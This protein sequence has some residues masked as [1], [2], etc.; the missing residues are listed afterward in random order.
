MTGIQRAALRNRAESRMGGALLGGAVALA[1]L[2]SLPWLGASSE[3]PV[4]AARE[5]RPAVSPAPFGPGHATDRPSALQAHSGPAG[6]IEALAAIARSLG[7]RRIAVCAA[8]ERGSGT[9]TADGARGY[10]AKQPCAGNADEIAA[11][12]H[13]LARLDPQAVIFRGTA[14]E[15]ATFIETLRADGSFAMVLLPSSTDRERLAHLLPEHAR[16]WVAVAD[17]GIEAAGASAERR[18]LTVA[19]LS[20][21]DV[22]A[23]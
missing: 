2:A 11:S 12:A 18:T 4:V 7:M 10:W 3:R 20:S 15:A 6:E 9:E 13:A 21:G 1:L 19:M 14:E 17:A 8:T 16:T 22:R 23:R 5:A